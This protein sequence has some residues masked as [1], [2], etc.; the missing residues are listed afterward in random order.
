MSKL[1]RRLQ[2]VL[3]CLTLLLLGCS[4]VRPGDDQA[5]AQKFYEQP[6]QAQ[7]GA[8]H[9]HPPSDQL[10][11]Y[12]YGNQ[13][14]HPPAI[15]LARCFALNGASA[16]PLL[17]EKLDSKPGDLDVR[18]IAY[19]LENIDSMGQYD[20]SSDKVLMTTL[21][22]RVDEMSDAGW[23]KI[24]RGEVARLSSGHQGPAQDAPECH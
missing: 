13:Q 16:I 9:T 10:A 5:I 22:A 1:I 6:V 14:R 15:Y 12:F 4:G 2:I 3:P 20:V 24:A 18:D 7:L 21:A 11:L 17:K 23:Q 8:F 19:L